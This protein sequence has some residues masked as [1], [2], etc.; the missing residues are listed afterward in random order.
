MSKYFI[1]ISLICLLVISIGCSKQE[2]ELIYPKPIERLQIG[3]IRTVV[4]LGNSI[5]RSSPLP[6]IG[7]YG[8]WGMAASKIDSDF[9]HILIR[10]IQVKDKNTLIKFKN[11]ANFETDFMQFP[12]SSLDSL[13]NADFIII[14][15]AENVEAGGVNY[16]KF[17]TQYDELIR[18][19]DP[20]NK[21]VKLV[22]DGF[23]KRE[24]V[25]TDIRNY[26][27]GKKYPLISITDLSS[28]SS[29]KGL[30][31][32]PT[33]QGMREIANRIWNYMSNYF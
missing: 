4:I 19:L 2:N 32:H 10:N 23:W 28:L 8:D 12:L 30:A 14:K 21:A 17:I 16:Q 20:S 18:Y 1:G 11:I 33:D 29:N 6:G 26:A 15:I 13:R 31:G 3:K 5:V 27:L 7:C 24:P 22:V 25:N 9:V